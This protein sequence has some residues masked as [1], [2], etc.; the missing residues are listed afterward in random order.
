MMI[1]EYD[2]FSAWRAPIIWDHDGD[3][4][5]GIVLRR[6]TL[7]HRH[8][9]IV[10]SED[11]EFGDNA[12]GPEWNGFCLNTRFLI[13]LRASMPYPLARWTLAHEMGHVFGSTINN[14]SEEF[15]S[16]AACFLHDVAFID[17][18]GKAVWERGIAA[19]TKLR[20]SG[21]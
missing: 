16:L 14:H 20:D 21:E 6:I 12:P 1:N 2:A 18:V 10:I 17:P 4:Y 19:L 3:T 15:A 8:Y 11:H 13:I 5:Q 7:A 9:S